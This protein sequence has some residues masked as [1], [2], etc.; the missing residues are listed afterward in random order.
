M[1]SFKE[2]Y[3]FRICYQ[4]PVCVYLFGKSFGSAKMQRRGGN[5]MP[6]RW[7]RRQQTTNGPDGSGAMAA[8]RRLGRLITDLREAADITVEEAAEFIERAPSTMWRLEA[9]QPGVR[10]RPHGDIGRLCEFYEV[11]EETK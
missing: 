7:T 9:G 6:R 11:D 5:S 10:I 8:R 3:C 2:A 4:N 1:Q